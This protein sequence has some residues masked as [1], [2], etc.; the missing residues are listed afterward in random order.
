MCLGIPGKVVKVEGDVAEVDF[1]GV[2]RKASLLL[3]P[4]VKEGDYVLVHVGFVITK[5][6]EEE[7]QETLKLFEEFFG[8]EA[9]GG[10]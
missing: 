1:W 5:L 8:E 6:Q 2:K 10:A 9:A 4:E 3:V 7:A